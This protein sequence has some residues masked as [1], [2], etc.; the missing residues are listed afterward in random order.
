MLVHKMIV[1]IIT[2]MV[3]TPKQQA[4]KDANRQMRAKKVEKLS[5][6]E[7]EVATWGLTPATIGFFSILA[8]YTANE[9]GEVPINMTEVEEEWARIGDNADD[10]IIELR[11]HDLVEERDD[12]SL[13]ITL[14]GREA[15]EHIF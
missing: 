14:L 10:L 8:P 6:P 13:Y 9:E 7:A 15:L 11:T 12:G 5:K 2:Y 1:S 4:L 3:L